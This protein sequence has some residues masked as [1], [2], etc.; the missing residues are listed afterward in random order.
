MFKKSSRIAL[1]VSFGLLLGMFAVANAFAAQPTRLVATTEP[2]AARSVFDRSEPLAIRFTLA[3]ESDHDVQVLRWH[4]PLDGFTADIFDVRLDGEP[5]A[6]T[7]RLVK[8]V[9]P[10][11]GDYVTIEAGGSVSAVFDPSQGYDMSRSGRY[12]IRYRGEFIETSSTHWIGPVRIRSEASGDGEVVVDA[13]EASFGVEGEGTVERPETEPEL[14][15]MSLPPAYS[16]CTNQQ[17]SALSTALG[18]AENMSI[19]SRSYL[20]N[21]PASQRPSDARYREWFGSYDAGRY[22]TVNGDFVAIADAFSN[23]TVTFFCDCT[24]SSYAYVYPTRP[25]EI[26]LCNA[27]WTAPALGT[28]SKAGTLVHEMSHFDVVANTNDYAYGQAACRKLATKSPKK[29]IHNADSHEYFA[30]AGLH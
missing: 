8:R 25:Y 27:F 18:N 19:E 3:N 20:T 11:P 26:H 14:G 9:A 6:Y 1:E 21:L 15:T 28:D 5:V 4:T 23:K 2:V 30:E 12:T 22:G 7:G 13:R 16:G 17:R 29:A 10:T 24:D